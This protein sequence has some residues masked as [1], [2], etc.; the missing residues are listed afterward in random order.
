MKAPEP[1]A[2]SPK[3]MVPVMPLDWSRSGCEGVDVGGVNRQ[4]GGAACRTCL[5]SL[6]RWRL[7]RGGEGAADDAASASAGSATKTAPCP[8]TQCCSALA[9]CLSFLSCAC[10]LSLSTLTS[11][12]KL[13]DVIT[14]SN[15][16]ASWC[17]WR[18][19]GALDFGPCRDCSQR[20]KLV[21][22]AISSAMVAIHGGAVSGCKLL[23]C[24]HCAPEPVAP[25]WVRSRGASRALSAATSVAVAWDGMEERDG[26][27]SSS[28]GREG[29]EACF[30]VASTSFGSATVSRLDSCVNVV[31][32]I[33]GAVTCSS[34]TVAVDGSN[35]ASVVVPTVV[36]ESRTGAAGVSSQASV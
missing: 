33:N 4:G 14:D 26:G 8:T 2:T 21:A 29:G 20:Q 10:A 18:C 16:A 3:D 35:Q 31:S 28:G 11:S 36:L 22:S 34:V 9:R 13:F 25:S 30:R 32:V 7:D 17:L 27:P 24:S 1:L 19:S 12:A 23:F 15:V 5:R 6:F